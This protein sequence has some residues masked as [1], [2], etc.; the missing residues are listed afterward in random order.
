LNL[1]PVLCLLGVRVEDVV[2]RGLREV[3]E[4]DL[5]VPV[6][7]GLLVLGERADVLV[8]RLPDELLLLRLRLGGAHLAQQLHVRE[9]A[10]DLVSVM[11]R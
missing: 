11:S 8:D 9:A 1:K 4:D 5:L 2:D 7:E 3:G 6:V 10:L